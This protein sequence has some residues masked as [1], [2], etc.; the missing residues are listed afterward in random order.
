MANIIRRSVAEVQ[1]AVAARIAAKHKEDG[2]KLRDEKRDM[3][4]DSF[5]NSSPNRR[6][7][8]WQQYNS[9]GLD[10]TLIVQ[11]DTRNRM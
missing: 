1:V 10:K 3:Y 6:A 4:A 7:Q 9:W 2:E 5:D 8:T 11:R